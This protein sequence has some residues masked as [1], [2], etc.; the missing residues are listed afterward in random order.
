VP[1]FGTER[2]G[3]DGSVFEVD[4]DGRSEDKYRASQATL[5]SPITDALAM[6]RGRVNRDHQAFLCCEKICQYRSML[7]NFQYIFK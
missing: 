7:F 6:S 3:R 1:R 5:F 4:L 2:A